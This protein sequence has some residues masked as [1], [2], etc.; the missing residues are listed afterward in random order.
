MNEVGE[1]EQTENEIVPVDK[2]QLFNSTIKLLLY[3]QHKIEDITAVASR[4]IVE[5]RRKYN[6][7]FEQ[8]KHFLR[9]Y[10]IEH[11]KRDKDGQIKGKSYKTLEAG[12]GIF[13]RQKPKKITIDERH[14]PILKKMLINYFPDDIV[15]ELITEKIAYEVSDKDA[16]LSRLKLLV[17]FRAQDKLDE[18]KDANPE[19]SEEQ[20]KFARE[21]LIE[22]GM[23]EMF[24][25]SIIQIDEADPFYHMCPGVTKANT[26]RRLKDNVLQAIDGS[27]PYTEEEEVDLLIEDLSNE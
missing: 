17:H 14:L 12:G 19:L 2:D 16:L 3:Y 26:F 20:K 25:E 13:F 24:D 6:F 23:K 21:E 18:L 27:I 10:T 9:E 22:L 7:H 15:N 11:L 1:I 8:N 4:F 5:A